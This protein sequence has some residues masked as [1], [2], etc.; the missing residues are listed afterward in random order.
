MLRDQYFTLR[1]IKAYSGIDHHRLALLENRLKDDVNHERGLYEGQ[2]LVHEEK[3]GVVAPVWAPVVSEQVQTFTDVMHLSRDAAG[4]PLYYHR[5][6]I[7][8][9]AAPEDKDFEVLLQ[10]VGRS[11]IRDS[12]FILYPSSSHDDL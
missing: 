5:I 1:N 10:I 7:T 9:E 11:N 6:P 3:D 4:L 2:V 8:A 12:V